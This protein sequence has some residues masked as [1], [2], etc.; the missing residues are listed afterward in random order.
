M[1]N[2][3]ATRTRALEASPDSVDL[4]VGLGNALLAARRPAEALPLFQKAVGIR[5]HDGAAF[6]GLG[7]AQLDLDLRDDALASFRQTLSIIPYDRYAAHM[8]DALSG[9]TG[10]KAGGYVPDLFDA[11]ASTFDEHLTGPLQ[12]RIPQIIREFLDHPVGNALDLGCGTGLVAEALGNLVAAIDGIDISHQMTRKALERGLYRTLQ[13]GDIVSIL[14]ASP[15]LA[16]HY[17]LVIAADVFVYIGPLEAVFAA[18]AERLAADGRFI[19]SVEDLAGENLA[20]RSS[21]RYAHSPAYI[22][23]V[24]AQHGLRIFERK[25]VTIRQERDMPIPGSLYLAVRN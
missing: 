18:V 14:A 24:A 20:I 17:D 12:Y 7:Q 25:P 23:A 22:D 10:G 13:T 16:G 15:D 21:G 5:T 8:V 11:Y 2:D 19:F 6:R 1:S 4:L 9:A 3:I